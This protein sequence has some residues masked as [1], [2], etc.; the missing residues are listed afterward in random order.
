[1]GRPDFEQTFRRAVAPSQITATGDI[2]AQGKQGLVTSFVL[3][4]GVD[5]ATAEI[6]DGGSGGTIVASISAALGT[7]QQVEYPAGMWF[8][9][10]LYVTLTGTS[11]TLDV[12][13]V[14]DDA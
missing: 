6:K 13:G 3:T 7:S 11:P 8:S 1:M 5:A 14:A 9:D 4:A 12:V 10:G 2:Y